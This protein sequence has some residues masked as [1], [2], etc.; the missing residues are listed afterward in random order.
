VVASSAPFID[1]AINI[2]VTLITRLW[3]QKRSVKAIP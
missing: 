3:A 1:T 2:N